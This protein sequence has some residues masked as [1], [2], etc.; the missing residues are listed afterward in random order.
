M[1]SGCRSA[2]SWRVTTGSADRAFGIPVGTA[3]IAATSVGAGAIATPAQ[4]KRG[5]ATSAIILF[6]EAVPYPF[7]ARCKAAKTC[8]ATVRP[9]SVR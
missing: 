3:M 4:Q 6:E 5:I 7:A 8:L 1:S 9:L 2:K